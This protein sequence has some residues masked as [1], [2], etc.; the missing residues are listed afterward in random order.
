[1]ENKR[2][3]S[4]VLMGVVATQVVIIGWLAYQGAYASLVNRFRPSSS[5]AT[6]LQEEQRILARDPKLGTELP[7]EQLRDSD[8][9][10]IADASS[11]KSIGILFLSD[12]TEC[13][14]DD[15]LGHWDKIQKSHPELRLYVVSSVNNVQRMREFV[16][17]HKLHVRFV[18]QGSEDLIRVCNP[19][20]LP[21]IY[22]FDRNKRLSY[23]QPSSTSIGSALSLIRKKFTADQNSH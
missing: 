2:S 1:M 5:E 18:V 13:A 23:V 14:A 20:F 6:N 9:R 12:C 7:V 10:S 17:K 16:T 4:Q 3:L 15:Y 8:G 11:G 19:F 22:L 21:R